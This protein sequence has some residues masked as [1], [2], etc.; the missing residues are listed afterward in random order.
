MGTRPKL[1]ENTPAPAGSVAEGGSLYVLGLDPGLA[2]TG[3]G[4][5]KSSPGGTLLVEA[6]V[7]RISRSKSLED[8]LDELYEGV[9]EL[10]QCWPIAE[11]AIEQLYSHY[12][13]PRT[14]ILM[15]HAR[16]VLYLA[17]ARKKLPVHAYLPTKVKK[18]MT[19]NGHASKPQMQ[20]AV[21]NQLRLSTP[22]EPHDVADALAIALCHLS[23]R[24]YAAE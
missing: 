1:A 13:R 15:G 4:I 10:L 6:G 5:L 22:L 21:Q 14:A 12:S 16:G 11:V 19:G 24:T 8:R 7:I 20:A 9:V 2:V 3:Y 18:Y 23:H 17:A